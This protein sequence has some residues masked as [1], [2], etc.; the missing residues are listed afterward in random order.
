MDE[1]LEI[2]KIVLIVLEVIT[3]L[4]MVVVILVQSGKQSGLSGAI[5]GNSDS[6][7]S[8]SGKGGLDK[9]LAKST[10]WLALA[11]V[12]LTLALALISF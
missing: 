6:Y 5:S 2:V 8:K 10:K 4:A 12:L 9:V 3:S 7:M 11:W 1:V